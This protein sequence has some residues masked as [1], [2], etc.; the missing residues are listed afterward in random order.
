LTAAFEARRGPSIRAVMPDLE[1]ELSALQIELVD[2][3]EKLGPFGME[4]PV[5]LL[6]VR[7]VQPAG[8]PKLL[9]EKHIKVQLRK[10]RSVVDAI[11][12]N[13]D[14]PLPPAPWDVA[15]E[16]V[17]NVSRGNVSAQLQIKHLRSAE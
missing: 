13:A 3:Y 11:W 6:L 1:V 5:P 12:F 15:F 9:K 10:G 14:A 7:G 16:L 4:N 8:S 17:R 2:V